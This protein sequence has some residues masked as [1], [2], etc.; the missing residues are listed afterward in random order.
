MISW[1]RGRVVRIGDSE[2]VI[3]V[4]GVGYRVQATSSTIAVLAATE[5]LVE[6]S[7]HTM[8]R[9]DAIVLFGFVAEEE[10]QVFEILLGIHNVGPSLALAIL[11]SLGARGVIDAVRSGDDAAFESVSGV[12]KK[13]AARISLELQGTKLGDLAIGSAPHPTMVA[14][15][16]ASA[17]LL[18]LGYSAEEVAQTLREID[19]DLPIE[20]ILRLALRELSRS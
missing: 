6:V 10:R 2:A 17:A 20:E 1:L 11:G 7:V 13:T 12:G 9:Q 15:G 19:A 18:G 5:G 14:G 3:D 4:A 16:E 8:M